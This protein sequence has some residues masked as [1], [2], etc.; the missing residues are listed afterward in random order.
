M[1]E[2]PH[3]DKSLP[4]DMPDG[5]WIDMWGD[6]VWIKDRRRHRTDGPALIRRNGTRMWF[7]NGDR[8]RTDGPAIIYSNGI[9]KWCLND[10]YYTLEE[11]LE[12]NDE[13]TDKQKFLLKLKYG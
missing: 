7:Q 12:A 6:E 9:V 11:W 10:W 1:T 3:I 4:H 5:Q 8:H 2:I 13:I